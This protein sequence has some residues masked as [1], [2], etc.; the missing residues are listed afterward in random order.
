[1]LS[2]ILFA[3]SKSIFSGSLVLVGTGQFLKHK[4]KI[5]R[6]HVQL[7]LLFFSTQDKKISLKLTDKT[8]L[9]FLL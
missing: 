6:M 3:L 4:V 5:Q 7:T 1:M 2:G 8:F 9:G